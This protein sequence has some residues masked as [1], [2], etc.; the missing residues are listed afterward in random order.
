MLSKYEPS[1]MLNFSYFS[2][3]HIRKSEKNNQGKLILIIYLF[4]LLY[5]RYCY[6][7]YN[8]Y[9]NFNEIFYA[10]LYIFILKSHLS[11]DKLNVKCSVGTCGQWVPHE[12]V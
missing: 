6:S 4:N 5:L 1:H 12:S 10:F 11:L 2:K 7:A 3:S 9:K 8:H